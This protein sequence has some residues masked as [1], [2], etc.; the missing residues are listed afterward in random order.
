QSVFF[1]DPDHRDAYRR[2]AAEQPSLL[3]RGDRPLLLD[4][5]QDAPQ[6]WDAV[7]FAVDREP[8]P[9]QFILTGST[10]ADDPEIRHSGTGRIARV[11]MRTMSLAESGDSTG[12]VSLQSLPLG[13]P[14]DGHTT[15]G[16]ETV[17]ALITRGG[18]PVSATRQD[19]FGGA[20]AKDYLTAIAESDVSRVDGVAKNPRRVQLLLRSLA[21]NE[22]TPAAMTTLR[23]DMALDESDL[24]T[25]TIGAY[26]GALR[27]LYV[28]EDQPAWPL[29]VRSKTAI[30]TSAIRRF[31]DP[32]LPAAL[33][34]LSPDKL[35]VDFNTF[36]LLFES[37]CIRDL[38]V[39][40][41]AHGASVYAYH[42]GRGLEADAIIE[43]PDGRWG[44]VEIKLQSTLEDRAAD[45]L[46]RVR[47]LVHSQHNGEA[48]FLAV[49]TPSGIA[50]RRPDG[51]YV[52]PITTLTA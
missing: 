28:I 48:S 4:E 21:R 16:L 36:G 22:S 13:R 43:W 15:A 35:L 47:H 6:I 20:R 2:I 31:C 18:W 30:R 1:Q 5:W 46:L 44:A 26:L 8:R 51:V 42:D 49:I 50:R 34:D 38:R 10:V 41:E 40:A 9:G 23:A 37:L 45:T 39:Y 3:L 29:A 12:E 17:A 33:L 32:S 27:R 24:S 19:E 11:V 14:I 52:V 7:R 25:N